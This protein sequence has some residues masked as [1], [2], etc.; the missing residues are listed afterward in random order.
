[1]G[2]INYVAT[3]EGWAYLATVIDLASQ[4]V[5]G[6]AL[7]DHMRTDLIAEALLNAFESRRRPG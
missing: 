4:R 5:V 7:G 6:W 3:W 1:V 2:D